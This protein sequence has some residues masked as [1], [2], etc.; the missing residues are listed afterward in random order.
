MEVVDGG[1][2]YEGMDGLDGSFSDGRVLGG[3]LVPGGYDGEIIESSPS[4]T[5]VLP[6]PAN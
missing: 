4:G 5:I 1:V 6:G 2:Y 3:S